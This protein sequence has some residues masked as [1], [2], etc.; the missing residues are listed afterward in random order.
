MRFRDTV[1]VV[2]A[3]TTTPPDGGDP[4]PN[5]ATAT[6]VD[7]PGEFQPL[8]STENVVAQQRTDSTH[9]AFLPAGADVKTTDR[10]RHLGLEY[11]VD[12]QPERWRIRGRDHHLE[13]FCFR[14]TGG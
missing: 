9:R 3:G 1:T 7:Y 6:T 5:W 14:V 4:I 10:L 8:S 13:V 12:G 11:E 2:R